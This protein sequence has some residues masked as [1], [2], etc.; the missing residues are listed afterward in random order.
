MFEVSENTKKELT[1]TQR[2]FLKIY[3][4]MGNILRAAEAAG[5]GRE[6]HY[7]WL[8]DK[9]SVYAEEFERQADIAAGLLED[10]AFRRAYDGNTEPVFQGGEQVGNVTKYSD[11]LLMFLLKGLKPYKYSEKVATQGAIEV[12]HKVDVTRER[13]EVASYLDGLASA[14]EERS[15]DSR[16][17]PREI[18][19]A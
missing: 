19:S 10:E 15:D 2:K 17:A 3:V 7:A 12:T 6:N 16:D 14:V 9:G 18:G 1:R 11:N 5:I 8:R 13:T 4:N